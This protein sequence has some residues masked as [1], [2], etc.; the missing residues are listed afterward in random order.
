MYS[1]LVVSQIVRVQFLR[2][3]LFGLSQARI[4]I[5]VCACR[6]SLD[7]IEALL[8]LSDPGHYQQVSDLFKYPL[9]HCPDMLLLGLLQV[10]RT[11]A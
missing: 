7:L 1:G 9:Q 10:V 2:A 8:T 4:T 3:N 6:K 5:Y 11:S